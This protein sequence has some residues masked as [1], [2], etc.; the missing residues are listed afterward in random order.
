LSHPLGL[1]VPPHSRR[2]F[3][4]GVHCTNPVDGDV[5][6]V[7][8]VG[9]VATG[10]SVGERLLAI[11]QR[12]LRDYTWLDHTAIIR[13]VDGKWM[14]SEFGPRGWEIR[15]LED[16]VDRLY[17]VVHFDVSDEARANILDFDTSC[18]DSTYGWWQYLPIVV[19]GLTGLKFIG[20]WGD[21]MICSTHVTYCMMGAGFFPAIQ[22][23]SITP[24]HLALWF[25]AKDPMHSIGY[26]HP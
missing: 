19:D 25:G 7:R 23:G 1:L 5:I 21:T 10:I 22:P 4:E 26:R 13:L 17:C 18:H 11:S 12:E 14:V 20:G 2:W 24:S 3:P 8:H 16:Y 15:D 9:D 6:L